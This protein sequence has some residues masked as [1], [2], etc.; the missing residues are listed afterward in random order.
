MQS[1]WD[2][3]DL[4]AVTRCHGLPSP[5]PQSTGAA[6]WGGPVLSLTTCHSATRSGTRG[7]MQ[8][9][10]ECGSR[11]RSGNRHHCSDPVTQKHL[12]SPPPA[13]APGT[14]PQDRLTALVQIAVPRNAPCAGR[15]S[16]QGAGGLQWLPS[17]ASLPPVPEGAESSSAPA[18]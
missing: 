2:I 7:A 10:A 18:P 6:G 5:S 15:R 1:I 9:C 12:A 4:P 11:V 17:P 8:V 16:G 14:Q 3:S 13:S